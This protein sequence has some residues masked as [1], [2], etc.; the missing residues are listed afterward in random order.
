M[1]YFYALY[2]FEAGFESDMV[3]I[4]KSLNWLNVHLPLLRSRGDINLTK[5]LFYS[6]QFP[7]V[8]IIELSGECNPEF[9]IGMLLILLQLRS[10]FDFCFIYAA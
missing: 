9:N 3:L 7:S 6:N 2:V 8:P 10:N 1:C 4:P 5:L